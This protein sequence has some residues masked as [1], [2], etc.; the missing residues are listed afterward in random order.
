MKATTLAVSSG[1]TDLLPMVLSRK[2][3]V[4]S[5][6]VQLTLTDPRDGQ[7]PEWSPG[8]HIDLVLP[9][10][11]IR[12]YS[13]CGD[14]ADRSELV[15]AVLRE[16]RSRGGSAFVHDRLREGDVIPV[17]GPRNA[18]PTVGS[19]RYLFIAGGIGITPIVPM[20]VRAAEKGA[21][22]RLL[23]GGR[24]RASMAF[25]AD[26]AARYPGLVEI[27][28]QDESGLLDLPGLFAGPDESAAIYCCGP[29]P[30][31]AAVEEHAALWPASTL[32][33]ERFAG[34]SWVGEDRPFELRLARSGRTVLV[35]A[36]MSALDALAGAGIEVPTSCREGVCGTCETVVLEGAPEHRDALLTEEERAEDVV[37][38]PCVSRAKGPC[39]IV[40]L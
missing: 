15:V 32:H 22:W 4:A 34:R 40:D 28:P 33:V 31:I 26:L 7:V 30:L 12:Q 18:F 36:A 21:D 27:R 9:G 17:R 11:L 29:E 16:P 1:K 2:D 39:L 20:A 25:S 6:V 14:P 24:K 19:E 13:L 23:H 3:R 8:A 38:F 10:D 35:P 37:F 5:G